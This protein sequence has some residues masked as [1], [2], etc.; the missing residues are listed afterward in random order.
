MKLDPNDAE[1]FC[2]LFFPLLDY[3]NEKYEIE[4]EL[5]KIAEREN[6]DLPKLFNVAQFLWER[7]PLIDEYLSIF[8][9]SGENREI[10]LAWKR[11]ISGTFII[12]RHLKKGSVFISADDSSVYLVNGIYSDWNEMT[13]GAPLP[14]TVRT[15]LIPFKDV[16][17]SDG[18]AS[19]PGICFGRNYANA[20]KE[21]YMNAKRDGTLKRKI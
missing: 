7:T 6:P 18:L 1:L 5:G 12:E 20:L 17:I 2:G 11:K 8:G 10:V 13:Q 4:P 16:I 14:F 19:A 21:I 3:V 9:I 15:T